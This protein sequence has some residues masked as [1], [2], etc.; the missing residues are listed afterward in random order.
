MQRSFKVRRAIPSEGGVPVTARGGYIELA[1]RRGQIGR[2]A[3]AK[4]RRQQWQ[5]PAGRGNLEARWQSGQQAACTK[6]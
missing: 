1:A 6:E 2:T 4:R 5:G 3:E